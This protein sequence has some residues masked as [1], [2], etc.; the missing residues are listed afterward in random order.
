MLNKRLSL[1]PRTKS[2]KENYDQ[3]VIG[4]FWGAELI[5]LNRRALD[6]DQVSSTNLVVGA[7]NNAS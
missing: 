5:P 1:A 6:I 4:E 2:E 3:T 7:H